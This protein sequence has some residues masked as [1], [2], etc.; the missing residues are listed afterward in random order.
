M[1]KSRSNSWRQRSGH[2]S[3][4]DAKLRLRNRLAS[5][6]WL[7]LYAGRELQAIWWALCLG[8]AVVAC[9]LLIWIRLHGPERAALDLG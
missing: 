8:L 4:V 7:V 6:A 3:Q 1:L 5:A 9:L 2:Y